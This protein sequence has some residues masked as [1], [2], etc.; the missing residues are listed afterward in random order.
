MDVQLA[1]PTFLGANSMTCLLEKA[2][3][4]CHMYSVLAGIYALVRWRVSTFL[5]L[6]QSLEFRVDSEMSRC[7]TSITIFTTGNGKYEERKNHIQ[8]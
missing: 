7:I 3:A 1:T 2:V 8:Q 4:A 5:P 6:K